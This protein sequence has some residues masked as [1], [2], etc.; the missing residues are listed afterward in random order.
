MCG[1]RFYNSRGRYDGV[2]TSTKTGLSDVYETGEGVLTFKHPQKEP[3]AVWFINTDFLAVQYHPEYM[4][5]DSD[6]WRYYQG[7]L[8]EYVL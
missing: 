3:E 8:E 5:H 1:A 4:N 2:D 6:G 7:L